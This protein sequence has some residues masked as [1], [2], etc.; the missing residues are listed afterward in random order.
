MSYHLTPVRMAISE[1]LQQYMLQRMQRKGSS[2]A[3]WWE[4]KSVH[5]LGGKGYE[6]SFKKLNIDVPQDP[7][8]P[9]L[10]VDMERTKI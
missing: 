7:A 3:L 5:P 10:G 6:V 8:V 1:N 2:L 4:C 9:H